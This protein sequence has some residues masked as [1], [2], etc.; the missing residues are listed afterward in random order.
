MK[1]PHVDSKHLTQTAYNNANKIDLRNEI[2]E[3]YGDHPIPWFEWIF[4]WLDLSEQANILELGCGSGAFWQKNRARVPAGWNIAL[5][6]LSS[7]MVQTAKKNLNGLSQNLA[8]TC[9]DS[10][11]LPF[12]DNH[13]DAVLAVGQLDYLPSLT[14][15]LGEAWRVL[16]PSGQFLA[17]AGGANHLNELQTLVQPFVPPQ[18]AEVIGGEED[19]F[20][21]EN[22]Q[23]KLDS[24]FQAVERHDYQTFMT[25]HQTQPVL[26][27]V[28]SETEFISSMNAQELGAFVHKV[29][30]HIAER[31]E[32]KVTIEK[33]VFLAR[34]K[35]VR[36]R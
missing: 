35:P 5:S 33:G 25:F 17:S 29:K 16:R 14:Q 15:A 10:Q 7:Q 8:Y 12:A 32:L 19:R 36:Q 21:L 24:V 1:D 6:D 4:R 20:G 23:Q 11:S 2:Q 13:F 34:K 26:D 31:G 30:R 28:F 9:F 22:G 3:D 18:K 27:Y